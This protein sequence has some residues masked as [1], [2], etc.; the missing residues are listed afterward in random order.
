MS[1]YH[2]VHRPNGEREREREREREV[3]GSRG[4]WKRPCLKQP[5][6]WRWLCFTVPWVAGR[7]PSPCLSCVQRGARVQGAPLSPLNTTGLMV[8]GHKWCETHHQF[9]DLTAVKK[10]KCVCESGCV[11]SIQC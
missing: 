3:V 8:F 11:P 6:E 5:T 7:A 9:D 1:S 4:R 10:G 2:I